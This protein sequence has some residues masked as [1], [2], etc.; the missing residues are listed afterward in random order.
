MSAVPYSLR[1]GEPVR[2][3]FSDTSPAVRK[4]GSLDA[5]DFH[6][7]VSKAGRREHVQVLVSDTVFHLI[8]HTFHADTLEIV[9]GIASDLGIVRI[10]QGLDRRIDLDEDFASF[11]ESWLAI[12]SEELDE[13][14][15]IRNVGTDEIRE[16]VS[17]R[18]YAA[19]R[20]GRGDISDA[21]LFN[22]VD[23]TYLGIEESQ[24]LRVIDL[25]SGDLWD[26]HGDR[27]ILTARKELIKDL[28]RQG[29]KAQ[30][31]TDWPRVDRQVAEV[32]RRLAE[33]STEEQFQAVGLL[34]REVLISLAQAVHDP[35]RH[36]PLDDIAP[37]ETDAKRMLEAYIASE[38]TGSSNEALRRH[39]KASYALAVELQHK[40]TATFREA[41]LCVE[42]TASA[43]NVI[44]II[45]GKRDA[46]SNDSAS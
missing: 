40:R 8:Q 4:G 6:Y 5:T 36:P 12:R 20:L 26:R 7:Y 41:A 11:P 13:M 21:M 32:R 38:L 9:R 37:G 39:A 34:C 25:Y 46:R 10:L 31:S 28:E 44:A 18:V 27:S 19:W 33:S 2:I 43:V 17:S 3:E 22:R 14:L 16:Y 29:A 24:L 42:A 35:A 15:T 1:S 23:A 30:N 45:S